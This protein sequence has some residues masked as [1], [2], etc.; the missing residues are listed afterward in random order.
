M[1]IQWEFND[2]SF[3]VDSTLWTMGTQ[4]ENV[5]VKRTW[6]YGYLIKFYLRVRVVWPRSELEPFWMQVSRRRCCYC[7]QDSCTKR[8]LWEIR[9][10]WKV[11]RRSNVTLKLRLRKKRW[12]TT[13][14]HRIAL[15]VHIA[16]VQ[17]LSKLHCLDVRHNHLTSISALKAEDGSE[18]SIS[19]Y[20]VY[21]TSST[22]IRR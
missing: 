17:R 19:M 13:R 4:T 21:P 16:G 7:Y 11:K 15:C 22:P 6:T 2:N 12:R 3:F 9:L 10:M 5:E 1:I 18:F 14:Y 8:N 20:I